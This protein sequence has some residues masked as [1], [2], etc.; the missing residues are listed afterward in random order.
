MR[1]DNG[2]I[3]LNFG[4]AVALIVL[5]FTYEPMLGIL[6]AMIIVTAVAAQVVEELRRKKQ[7]K[8]EVEWRALY[9]ENIPYFGPTLV[10]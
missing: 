8:Q 6:G 2:S 4:M 5:G 9:G 1:S 3:L 10:K 7:M